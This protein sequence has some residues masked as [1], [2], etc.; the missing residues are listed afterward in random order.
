MRL[1]WQ[2]EMAKLRTL[3]GDT[4]EEH[5]VLLAVLGLVIVPLLLVFV[6]SLT[7][8]ALPAGLL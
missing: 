8:T 3:A 2:Q 5:A 1:W 6:L 4:A 7:G